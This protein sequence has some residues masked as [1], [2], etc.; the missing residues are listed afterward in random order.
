MDKSELKFENSIN[1]DELK[2][3]FNENEEIFFPPL[4][5]R[6]NLNDYLRKLFNYANFILG[7][8][9]KGKLVGILAFYM[10]DLEKKT[11]F[12]TSFSILKEF[13]GKGYSKRFLNEL[14][15]QMKES[16]FEKV[17]L[18]VDQSNSIAKSLYLGEGF[19]VI[20]LKKHTQI[21]EKIINNG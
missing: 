2:N 11:G 7:K 18:E 21:M 13:Q 9:Q 6:L 14:Y 5:T 17:K 12:I 3:Y 16:N 15:R 10:N 20:E 8:D 1:Y 19:H 4:S